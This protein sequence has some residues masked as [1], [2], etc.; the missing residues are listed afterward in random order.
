MVYIFSNSRIK[1]SVVSSIQAERHPITAL[2]KHRPSPHDITY[3]DISSF[4]KT[5]YNPVITRLKRRCVGSCWGIIDPKGI[6]DDP[7][8]LFFKGA[9]DYRGPTVYKKV[10]NNKRLNEITDY[11][12]HTHLI[13]LEQQ[14]EKLPIVTDT[15]FPGWNKICS[16]KTYPFCFLY[17]MIDSEIDLKARLGNAGYMALL[18]RFNQ[19]LQHYF[20]NADPHLWIQ[21]ETGILYLLP[22]TTTHSEAGVQAALRMLLSAPLITY[23]QMRLPF[24]ADFVFAMHIG[25]SK[26]AASGHTGQIVSEAINFIYHLGHRQAETG[27]ITVSKDVYTLFQSSRLKDFFVPAGTFENHT[28]FQSRRFL[29]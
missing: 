20:I 2:S 21:T 19:I 6:I 23:E 8:A 1:F 12:L 16:G 4:S 18:D 10:I 5:T 29:T 28:L 11:A 22:P 14:A 9:C 15:P 13:S 17:V 26:Y 3:I 7:A 27:R 24:W 25:S